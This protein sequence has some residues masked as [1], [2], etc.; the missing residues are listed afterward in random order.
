MIAWCGYDGKAALWRGGYS[1]E[2][3]DIG[4]GRFNVIVDHQRKEELLQGHTLWYMAA[5][6]KGKLATVTPDKQVSANACRGLTVPAL[7]NGVA[8]RVQ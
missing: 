8:A 2:V 1:V 7:E 3:V 5:T 6:K 4:K